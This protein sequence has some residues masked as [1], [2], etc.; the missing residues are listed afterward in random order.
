M[1][2]ERDG[3]CPLGESEAQVD[4]ESSQMAARRYLAMARPKWRLTRVSSDIRNRPLGDSR[5]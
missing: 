1:P 4:A 2:Q 3:E 5:N